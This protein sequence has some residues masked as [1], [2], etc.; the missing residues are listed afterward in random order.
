MTQGWPAPAKLNLFLHVTGRREDGYHELQTI[1]QF[2]DFSDRLRF[3]ITDDARI[4][5]ATPIDRLPAEQDL[6]VR[7]ARLLQRHTGTTKGV[8]IH[9]EKRIPL[10]GGLGGGSSDAA[11]TLVALNCLWGLGLDREELAAVGLKLGADIPVFVHGV[12]AWAE[13][14]GERLTPIELPEPWYVV[15]VPPVHV[16]T[17]QVFADP[18]LTRNSH[19]ITIR[20]FRAG[21][22]R[23][24]LEPVVRRRYPDVDRAWKWLDQFGSPRM[25][26]A[27]CCVY[28]TVSGRRDGEGILARVP[29]GFQGFVAKGLNRS[30]LLTVASRKSRLETN[31]GV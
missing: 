30:P 9:L 23:N 21:R 29:E 11:T 12:A 19:P 24:D 1:F 13:G 17:A 10:A 14:V 16:A 22:S 31:T 4:A 18:E 3:V 28:I 26:G 20:D 25:T 8:V 6:V 7:A 27:G 2:L 15:V 5:R